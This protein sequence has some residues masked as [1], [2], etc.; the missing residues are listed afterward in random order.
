MSEFALNRISK[1]RREQAFREAVDFDVF[2]ANAQVNRETLQSNFESYA[3]TEQELEWFD[4]LPETVDVLVL[5]HDWCGD[6][7]ANLPLFA[8]IERETG[9]KLKLRILPR[10]PGNRDIAELFPHEDGQSR[11][12]T[13]LF[14]RRS[15][16]ELGYFVERPQDISVL[17]KA[18]QERFWSANPWLAGRGRPI[19]ELE[20]DVRRALQTELKNRRLAVQS[21]EKEAILGHIRDIVSREK[22]QSV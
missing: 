20:E 17:L 11:I 10:D 2:V 14:F 16:E 21:L 18:W 8:R 15:G 9:A 22:E 3:L 7:A 1:E 6:A 12:P 13:Y 5:A 4:A 19:G